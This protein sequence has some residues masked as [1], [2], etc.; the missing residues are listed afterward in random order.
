LYFIYFLLCQPYLPVRTKR[1]DF[2]ILF[3]P[4]GRFWFLF[5]D[6]LSLLYDNTTFYLSWAYQSLKIA[7]YIYILVTTPTGR[8]RSTVTSLTARS[9]ILELLLA[10]YTF[11]K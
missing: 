7:I 6:S 8:G 3:G 9:L 2:R 4:Q 5:W 10:V 11:V 1:F